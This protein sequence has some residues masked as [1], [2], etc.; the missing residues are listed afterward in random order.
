MAQYEGNTYRWLVIGKGPAEHP[1]IR[2]ADEA[3]EWARRAVEL[4]LVEWADNDYA[5]VVE[6]TS[7]LRESC[8]QWPDCAD[9]KSVR[10][11]VPIFGADNLGIADDAPPFLP[12]IPYSIRSGIPLRDWYEFDSDVFL[13]ELEREARELV[14]QAGEYFSDADAEVARAEIENDI[15][16]SA[17]LAAEERGERVFYTRDEDGYWFGVEIQR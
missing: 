10:H 13:D 2:T 7:E 1:Q 11:I 17:A 8:V 5:V 4:G 3:P 9:D 15:G 16:W 6:E 14:T 12:A